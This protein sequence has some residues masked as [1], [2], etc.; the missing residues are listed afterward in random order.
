MCIGGTGG[1]WDILPKRAVTLGLYEILLSKK[2]HL[3]FMRSWHAGVL[4]RALFGKVTG[5]CP[6]SFVQTH[7]N[8]EVTLTDLA[9]TVPLIQ[10]AQ[11]I[12]E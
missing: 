9:A 2:I 3:M 12:A 6:G 7:K 4:R 1:N 5:R 10:V 11:R 8:I